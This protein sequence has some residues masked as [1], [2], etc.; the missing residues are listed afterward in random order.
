MPME[1]PSSTR[2]L[3]QLHRNLVRHEVRA[4][5]W[6]KLW[7]REKFN[8]FRT[9]TRLTESRVLV[10]I[11]I[12]EIS[13]SISFTDVHSYFRGVFPLPFSPRK[14]LITTAKTASFSFHHSKSFSHHE[15]VVKSTLK[16]N[17]TDLSARQAQ[18]NRLS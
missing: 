6:T 1:R 12:L 2:P 16:I 9:E 8:L 17:N 13:S 15:S 4:V 3:H 10:V 18:L 11:I 5:L 7:I 14:Y